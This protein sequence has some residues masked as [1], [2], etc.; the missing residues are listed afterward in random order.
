MGRSGGFDEQS[1][2]IDDAGLPDGSG[3][4]L[5]DG[6][7]DS[8]AVQGLVNQAS[9]AAVDGN[10]QVTERL[11][12]T[13]NQEL[14][15]I[16]EYVLTELRGEIATLRSEKVQLQ[17][18]VQELR[19][20]Q[21]VLLSDREQTQ[22]Q[23][24]A[25]Q[26]AQVMTQNLR[27]QI[28]TQVFGL[29]E[30]GGTMRPEQ[31]LLALHQQMVSL[32][33]GLGAA[34]QTLE[35]ELGQHQS[36]LSQQ[37]LRMQDLEQ[38]G[39]FLLGALVQKLQAQQQLQ[40]QQSLQAP[41]QPLPNAGQS[42]A[43]QPLA[44]ELLA[45]EAL[46]EGAMDSIKLPTDLLGGYS[47]GANPMGPNTGELSGDM[48]GLD[49]TEPG[50]AGGEAMSAAADEIRLPG[51]PTDV[52]SV[53]A[54]MSGLKPPGGDGGGEPVTAESLSEDFPGESAPGESTAS[55]AEV[56]ASP[57]RPSSRAAALPSPPRLT[58]PIPANPSPSNPSGHGP[59]EA[60][61]TDF[62]IDVVRPDVSGFPA[63]GAESGGMAQ[64][65]GGDGVAGAS[66]GPAGSVSFDVTSPGPTNGLS[67]DELYGAVGQPGLGVASP[68]ESYVAGRGTVGETAVGI[69]MP[70]GMVDR[71]QGDLEPP[72]PPAKP[73]S[74]WVGEPPTTISS[75]IELTDGTVGEFTSQGGGAGTAVISPSLSASG[76]AVLGGEGAAVASYATA[77]PFVPIS[78]SAVVEED[79]PQRSGNRQLQRS[80]VAIAVIALLLGAIQYATVQ[81][82]FHG[83]PWI[84]DGQ[85]FI[86]ATWS[87]A[88]VTFWIRM[89]MVLPFMIVIGQGLYPPLLPEMQAV[90]RDRDRIPLYS[91]AAS[92]L[93][94]FL[95]HFLL[96]G[97]IAS[98][99][100]TPAVALFFLYPVLGQLLG[101]SLFNQRLSSARLLAM[102]PL[103]LGV[104][105][106][107]V[108]WSGSG[109][110]LAGL[111]SG[112]CYALF[113]MLTA[114][115]GRRMN[116]MTLTVLQFG[117]AWLWAVPAVFFLPR[118][119][120]MNDVGYVVACA[121]LSATVGLS[122]L[123]GLA[124][125]RRLGAG[126]SAVV[127]GT[128]PLVVGVVCLFLTDEV[129]PVSQ[130]FGVLLITGGAV[131]LGFQR[132]SREIGR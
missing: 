48:T 29:S 102:V 89:L 61:I 105:W 49:W 103:I 118:A 43:A 85:G 42:F 87:S 110:Q 66:D 19:H 37:L 95:A 10:W 40:G 115:N 17:S 1:D 69:A 77:E 119:V 22:Q 99:S 74:P 90:F 100:A 97:S 121:V 9:Q 54:A 32:E 41:E 123:F 15:G 88:L 28:Q 58:T 120:P 47:V 116:P 35:Q 3:E 78:E 38:Q 71:V 20:Q 112:L 39:E 24:W 84:G 132:I 2:S 52:A 13:L 53:M 67:L 107:L 93:F 92:G 114:V 56:D 60:F 91:I 8:A 4:G 55:M 11:L 27:Q 80:G 75:L 128:L 68:S 94:L 62:P 113:L 21:D 73:V 127:Q 16:K 59:D 86:A 33:E 63:S 65:P 25:Q 96:Y 130:V 72:Q 50:L 124:S 46:T 5:R 101:W 70:P 30:S 129:L 104:L 79:L 7:E 34:I 64:P 82:L 18:Q 125:R 106:L 98:S 51:H 81:V 122:Q 57:P 6:Q 126:L 83:A 44:A 26:F 14:G 36:E 131:A 111:A 12:Q 117:L 109:G 23:Q 76:G 108:W 45:S 31:R